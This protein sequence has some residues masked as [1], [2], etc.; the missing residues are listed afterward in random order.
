MDNHHSNGPSQ[1]KT[2][3]TGV[4]VMQAMSNLG[5]TSSSAALQERVLRQTTSTATAVTTY[6]SSQ[7]DPQ[8]LLLKLGR[9]GPAQK[10]ARRSRSKTARRRSRSAS[11]EETKQSIRDARARS[12]SRSSSKTPATTMDRRKPSSGSQSGDASVAASASSTSATRGRPLERPTPRSSSKTGSAKTKSTQQLILLR[13]AARC[14]YGPDSADTR[15]KGPCPIHKHCRKAKELLEHMSLCD[16]TTAQDCPYPGCNDTNHGFMATIHGTTTTTSKTTSSHKKDTSSQESSQLEYSPTSYTTT[17]SHK[18]K[19]KTAAEVDGDI[20]DLM[21][22][23]EVATGMKKKTQ[24]LT[25]LMAPAPAYSPKAKAEDPLNRQV[26]EHSQQARVAV[27]TAKKEE[28]TGSKVGMGYSYLKAKFLQATGTE[29]EVKLPNEVHV[30]NMIVKHDD[31]ELGAN[32]TT[33]LYQDEALEQQSLLQEE[34]HR[35]RISRAP[36][37]HAGPSNSSSS[38]SSVVSVGQDIKRQAERILQKMTTG[39]SVTFGGGTAADNASSTTTRS[40]SRSGNSGIFRRQDKWAFIGRYCCIL[41]GFMFLLSVIAL[42]LL[43]VF[44]S[45]DWETLTGPFVET[46]N[47]EV[48]PGGTGSVSIDNRPPRNAPTMAPVRP[49]RGPTE[50]PTPFI[51]G[52]PDYS[53]DAIQEDRINDLTENGIISGDVIKSPQTMAYRWILGEHNEM[54]HDLDVSGGATFEQE[55]ARGAW[56]TPEEWRKRF[57]LAT[58]YFATTLSKSKMMAGRNRVEKS[59]NWTVSEHWLDIGV[60]VCEWSFYGCGRRD[61]LWIADNGLRGSYV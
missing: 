36:K 61:T 32:A 11:V 20:N 39:K 33:N 35:R 55:I 53:R 5:A 1:K 49:W 3:S 52:I 57:A 29:P 45:D 30:P 6:T 23:A 7:Y 31:V 18:A 13:H 8:D 54:A 14:P 40:S 24:R 56:F 28:S 12:R 42:I 17:T 41:S 59:T 37:S 38:N 10:A 21:E 16:V 47:K 15:T 27:S 25:S 46:A 60:S 51:E 19:K 50:A 34:I 48:G 2:V 4:S 26:I 9:N 58:F 43:Y 22:Q 44:A